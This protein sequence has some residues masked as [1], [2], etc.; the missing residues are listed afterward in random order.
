MGEI[1]SQF[2]SEGKKHSLMFLK[3]KKDGT[4]PDILFSTD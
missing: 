2:E 4:L 3:K 1:K